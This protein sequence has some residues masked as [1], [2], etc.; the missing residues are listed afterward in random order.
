MAVKSFTGGSD[1]QSTEEALLHHTTMVDT[2]HYRSQVTHRM[3][4]TQDGL[5]CN[6]HVLNN[7]D[8]QCKFTDCNKCTALA[9]DIGGRGHIHVTTRGI[10]NSISFLLNF[11]VNPKLW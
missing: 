2:C 10:W 5:L 3:Y 1:K 7:N 6:L 9:Q 8:V 4:M 11:V